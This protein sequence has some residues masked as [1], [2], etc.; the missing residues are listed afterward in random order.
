MRKFWVL[1]L[2]L[3][4]IPQ[5]WAGVFEHPQRLEKISS[6]VP[7][8]KD[9]SCH[10]AQEKVLPSSKVVIKSSGNFKFEKNKGVTFY[11]T[12]PIKS[13]NSYSSREY[14]QINSIISAISNKSYSRLERDFNFFYESKPAA[15][16]LGLMPKKGT[17]VYNYLK[18]IEISGNR[19]MITKIVILPVDLS[20]TTIWFRK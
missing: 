4:L 13:T 17:Q 2:G 19:E 11:T 8:L 16:Q 3:I 20:K 18:S 10:F 6:E 5:A 7:E 1:I 14:K 12:Y 15:W 9:I